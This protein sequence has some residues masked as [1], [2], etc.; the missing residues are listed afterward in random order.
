MNKM[1]ESRTIYKVRF[2]VVP[3]GEQAI[4][5]VA[6]DEQCDH[7]VC[8]IGAS[9]L[10]ENILEIK[11]VIASEQEIVLISKNIPTV[12]DKLSVLQKAA[13]NITSK[14]Q[15]KLPVWINPESAL[16]EFLTKQGMRIE[17]IAQSIQAGEYEVAMFGFIPGFTYLSG[18]REAFHFPRKSTP[19][20]TC[21]AGTVAIGGKFLGIYN[22]ASPAGWNILGYTPVRMSLDEKERLNIGDQIKLN[23]ISEKD[24]EVLSRNEPTIIEF[25]DQA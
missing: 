16:L 24:Y 9:L 25:N 14:R 4:R 3:Y 18:L 2:M 6:K 7:L 23:L 21:R 15:L 20:K 5:L 10:R 12:L 22:F 13:L 8:Q 1:Y 11:D 17:K 19:T